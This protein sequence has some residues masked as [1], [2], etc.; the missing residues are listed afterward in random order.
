[1]GPPMELTK[2]QSPYDGTA[3]RSLKERLEKATGPDRGL[4]IRIDDA[5]TPQIRGGPLPEIIHYLHDTSLYEGPRLTG[6]DDAAFDAI[7]QAFA[8]R[9]PC[10]EIHS[11]SVRTSGRWFHFE[12]I[13]I[14]SREFQGR[15][16][17][18]PIA[19]MIALLNAL[20]ADT[21]NER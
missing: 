7:E 17:V 21:E 11:R 4:D 18:R 5:L 19:K 10:M 14:P 2:S 12:E 13:T 20:I 9:H 8:P 3:L 6:S 15:H 16:A 1:M